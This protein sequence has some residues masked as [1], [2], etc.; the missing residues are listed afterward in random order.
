M[1]LDH[2]NLAVISKTVL[3]T[4]VLTATCETKL[5]HGVIAVGPG[6]FLACKAGVLIATCETDRLGWFGG[7]WKA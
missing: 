2:G 6:T 5:D 7:A 4:G 3:L 1:K